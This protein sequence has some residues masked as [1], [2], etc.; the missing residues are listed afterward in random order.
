MRSENKWLADGQRI[1]EAMETEWEPGASKSA[2]FYMGFFCVGLSL[3]FFP[4][5]NLFE[6]LIEDIP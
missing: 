3:I 5:P 2:T 6:G 4:I 1:K